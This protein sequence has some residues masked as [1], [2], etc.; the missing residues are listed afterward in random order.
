MHRTLYSRNI[1]PPG[2]DYGP[3]Q[4]G[5]HGPAF[6]QGGRSPTHA[7]PLYL[8][9]AHARPASPTRVL[10]CHAIRVNPVARAELTC[11]RG[12]LDGES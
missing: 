5:S 10:Q 12:R 2:P 9:H 4:V 11:P 8:S 7:E 6:L 3:R 1:N